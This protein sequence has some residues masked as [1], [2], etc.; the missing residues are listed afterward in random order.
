LELAIKKLKFKKNKKSNKTLDLDNNMER[1]LEDQRNIVEL[2]L[3]IKKLKFKKN[4]KSTV[5]LF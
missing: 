1:T 5:K 4:K 2:E 3:S